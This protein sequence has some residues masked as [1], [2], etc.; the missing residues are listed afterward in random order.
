MC[1]AC[2]GNSPFY[3]EKKFRDRLSQA[4]ATLLEDEWKGAKVGHRIR[5]KYGHIAYPMP[6]HVHSGRGVCRVCSSKIWDVFYVVADK[7]RTKVK[8][9]ITSGDPSPRL[10]DHRKDGYP[11]CVRIYED[12][13]GTMAPEIELNLIDIL[14][15][16][17]LKPIKGRE[18][19][20]ISALPIILGYVD[21]C[22]GKEA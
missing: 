5:C 17:G 12:M 9:G 19:F 18:Y 11:H 20:D 8:F 13:P 16:R 7:E 4:G 1:S 21:E 6:N 22:M 10:A 3:A 2:Y 14:K 15:A